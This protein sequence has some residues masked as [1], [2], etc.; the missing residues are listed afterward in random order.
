MTM[1]SKVAKQQGGEEVLEKG[2]QL[3]MMAGQ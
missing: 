2:K 1:N 3:G